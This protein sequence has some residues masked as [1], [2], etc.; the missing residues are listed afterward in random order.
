MK[1]GEDDYIPLGERARLV[2]EARERREI[3]KRL[4]LR[5]ITKPK[6]VS[7]QSFHWSKYV[8]KP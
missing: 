3:E 8:G 6:E 4:R 7:I 5:G 2:E 1:R